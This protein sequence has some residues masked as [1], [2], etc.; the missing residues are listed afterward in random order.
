MVYNAKSRRIVQKNTNPPIVR[1]TRFKRTNRRTFRKSQATKARMYNQV[2][3]VNNIKY[4]EYPIVDGGFNNGGTMYDIFQGNIVPGGSA[5]AQ[6]LGQAIQI[7]SVQI[8][9]HVFGADATNAIRVILFQR[10]SLQVNL[11]TQYVL[12]QIT[13]TS[14]ID[15]S[16]ADETI[17][18]RDWYI[19]LTSPYLSSGSY[20]GTM[21][22]N[23]VEAYVKGSKCVR[24]QYDVDNSIWTQGKLYLLLLSDSQASPHPSGVF[25]IR[26]T[27]TDVV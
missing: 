15:F 20:G 22:P 10:I 18:L 6:F 19:N 3:P 27:Y 25:S 14:M 2:V 16:H 11:T 8:R 26:V 4:I 23:I 7:R 9:G 24:S 17:I 12:E 21:N 1:Y 5:K 13:P